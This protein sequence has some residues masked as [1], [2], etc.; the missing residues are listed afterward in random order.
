MA[1]PITFS[2]AGSN[3]DFA[4]IR[5]AIVAQRMVPISQL[6]TRS[7]ALSNQSGALK[8]LNGLLASLTAAS[9]A[10]TD[11]TLGTDRSATSSDNSV[12]T[13][14]ATDAAT[15]G[16]M[17]LTVGR[18]ASSL[19][20]ASKSFTTVADPVLAGGAVSATFELRKGGANTGPEITIDS[21]NNSLAGLRDAINAANAGIS[22]SIIDL[23]GDGTRNQL[24]LTSKATG[25]A[26]RVELVET[27]AT[28][29]GAGLTMRSLNPVTNDFSDLDAEVTINGLTVN[30]SSNS[31]SDAVTG[32]TFTA[33]QPGNVTLTVGQSSDIGNKL[34]TFINAY[35]AVQDFVAAQ[36]QKDSD[37]KPTG[38]LAGD[39]TLR[40][41]QQQL[42]DSLSAISTTNGGSLTNLA[43][44]GI[45]RDQNAKLTLDKKALDESLSAG[46]A[47]VRA[48]LYGSDSDHT[49]IFTNINAALKDLSDN[50]TGVVQ[51]AINGY[52]SSIKTIARSIADQ[53]R[54]ANELK[55]SLTR[56]FA[57]LDAAIGQLN[58]QGSTLTT[59]M[60]S[61]KPRTN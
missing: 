15:P 12:L 17:A 32:V 45:G 51:T 52:E 34:Q 59:I 60:D 9:Q 44:L 27:S 11:K 49:G 38:V 53:T 20:Q 5:D 46:T 25:A 57:K 50:L 61:L 21:D 29:T 16:S 6:Q 28:G 36:Y 10:L 13:A 24:V 37:N 18:L 7:S 2:G 55:D 47:D 41:V 33:K 23:G 8:Q 4:S 35:N 26:G 31:I 30:R 48:L 43:N 58:S 40:L 1:N 39:P 54:R 22:A 14:S 42:R 3:I 19:S 56:Q